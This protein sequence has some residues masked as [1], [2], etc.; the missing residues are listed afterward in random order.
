M[1]GFGRDFSAPHSNC[2]GRGVLSNVAEPQNRGCPFF[3]W[4]LTS[5]TCFFPCR[6]QRPTRIAYKTRLSCRRDLHVLH[7][8]TKSGQKI[9][10]DRDLCKPTI[11]PAAGH[12]LRI[13]V[14]NAFDYPRNEEGSGKRRLQ[15]INVS[16]QRTCL[17]LDH[18]SRF[19][20][21]SFILRTFWT[22]EFFH[23]PEKVPWYAS[24]LGGIFLP[25][26]R[27]N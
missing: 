15:E 3:P 20:L 7:L 14:F 17:F 9:D 23:T 4:P 24:K 22:V 1:F 13:S 18:G 8:F 12:V 26:Q 11:Q 25:W 19:I 5:G 6:Q 27:A 21:S 2:G 16:K 10:P